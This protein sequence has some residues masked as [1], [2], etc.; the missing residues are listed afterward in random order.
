MPPHVAQIGF[1]PAPADWTGA[2]VLE[3]WPSLADIAEAAAAGGTRVSVVQAAARAERLSRHGVDYHF[4]D[5]RGA[6]RRE[7]GRRIAGLL[8]A[9]GVDLLHV[10]GLGFPEEAAA[11]ARCLPQLPMLLQD[12]ADRPP[13]R[14]WRRWQWRH[15]YRAAAGAAFTA[16]ELAWPFTSRRLLGAGTRLFAIPESS[17]RFRPGDRTRA[18]A[19]TGVYGDPAVLCVGHLQAGKDPL[20]ALDGVALAARRLPGLQ[21]WWAFGTAPLLAQV[22]ARIAR[23]PWLAG[24]VHLLGRVPHARIETLLQAA[25][26]FVSSSLGESCGYAALEAMACGTA[27]VLSDIPAFRALTGDGRVGQLW[28]RGDPPALADALVAAAVVRTPAAQV[29]AHFD[30]TLS[31]DAVGRRWRQ[32]YAQLLD[33]GRPA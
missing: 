30:A 19:A 8:A 21:L 2:Q 13:R 4:V 27:P 31:L 18:R 24:R 6:R 10:H 7:R 5:V 23:D 26:L 33:R 15:R 17:S 1:L 12:H 25:D 22:Q 29:R 11:V 9:L 14:W 3:R 16:P 28:R 32:A 20:T